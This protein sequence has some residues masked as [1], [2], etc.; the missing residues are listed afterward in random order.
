MKQL[1]WGND[2]YLDDY[3]FYNRTDDLNLLI[4]LLDTTQYG[5]SPLI[6]LT[7]IR[8]VG[9][10][11]LIKKSRQMLV[12]IVRILKK[13]CCCYTDNQFHPFLIKLRHL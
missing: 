9:K 1:S 11:V 13:V 4:N 5:S 10:T 6:L 2:G 7:G 3:E 8:R 12:I